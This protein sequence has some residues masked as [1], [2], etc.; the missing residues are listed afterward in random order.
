MNRQ[1]KQ[2]KWQLEK[3]REER[4]GEER[5]G[6]ETRN[7]ITIIDSNNRYIGIDR[8]RMEIQKKADKKN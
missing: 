4:R 8:N 1:Q 6:E 7:A 2:E 5:R 3:R